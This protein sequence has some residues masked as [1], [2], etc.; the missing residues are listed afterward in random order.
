MKISDEVY[1]LDSTEGNYVYVILG[2]EIIL[3]DTGRPKNGEGILNDLKSLNINP[4]DVKHILI[5]HNDFDHIGSLAFL[6]QATGAKIWASKED[7]PVI[8]GENHEGIKR[9]IK[10]IVKVKKPENIN[11]YPEDLKI[12]DIKVIPTPGHTRGH[13]SLLYKDIMFIG[14]LF[15]TPKGKITSMMSFSNWNNQIIKESIAKIDEYDFEWICPAHGEPIK[16]DGHLKDFIK[17]ISD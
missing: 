14:D 1:A 2:E 10:Y 15:R 6:E 8:C 3:I 5:T 16:R 17:K 13:V 7:I 11:A 9:I 4:K 12:G